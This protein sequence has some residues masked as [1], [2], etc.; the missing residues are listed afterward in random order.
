M[1]SPCVAAGHPPLLLGLRA[2]GETHLHQAHGHAGETAKAQPSPFPP[3]A[4][5]EVSGV[6]PCPCLSFPMLAGSS[7]C[8]A[9]DPAVTAGQLAL[10]VGEDGDKLW[11][12]RCHV[13]G[14]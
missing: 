10:V 7:G 12:Y 5:L 9:Q 4:L 6:S 3:R 1:R 13:G 8:T 14:Q 11:V 2:R